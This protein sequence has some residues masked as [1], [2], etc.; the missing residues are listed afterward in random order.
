MLTYGNPPIPLGLPTAE[1]QAWVAGSISLADVVEFARLSWPGRN[2]LGWAWPGIV[3]HDEYIH[4]G[5]LVWPVGATRFAHF[6]FLADDVTLLT[7]RAQVYG[8]KGTSY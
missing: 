4:L 7:L 3:D 8:Q 5:R 2:N 1:L 6:H